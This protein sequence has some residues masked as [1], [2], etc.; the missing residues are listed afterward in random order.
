V[1][2]A[3]QG[4]LGGLIYWILGM[5]AALLWGVAMAVLSLIP[6]VGAGL[7]W[8]PVAVYLFATGEAVSAVVLVLYGVL[9]IGLADNIL[10][11]ILVGRDTRMPDWLVLLSTLG[12]LVLFGINGFVIGPLIAALFIVFWQIFC[13]DF[14]PPGH[15]T[16]EIP[17]PDVPA[18]EPISAGQESQ[19]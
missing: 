11:P 19:P 8:A 4:A 2:A 17:P 6:A 3:V 13:R 9:V 14:Q 18:S 5:P 16:V 15:S 1:V 7:I 10:R 12:G